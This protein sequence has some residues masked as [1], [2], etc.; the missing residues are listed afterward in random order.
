[1]KRRV[2]VAIA[3]FTA[4]TAIA[5][6]LDAGVAHADPAVPQAGAVCG[7]STGLMGGVQAFSPQHEVLQCVKG[8]PMYVWQHQDGIQRPAVAW[9][10][11]G[12]QATLTKDDLVPGTKWTGFARGG[13]CSEQQT[14]TSGGPP[15]AQTTGG[16]VALDFTVLPDMATLTLQGACVWRQLES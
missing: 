6:I 3:T 10:T 13:D 11:Y 12:P 2:N 1:M 16:D 14:R 7:G 9:F 5:V 8:V 15:V 4:S